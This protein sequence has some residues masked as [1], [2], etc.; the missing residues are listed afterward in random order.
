M[1][2][3][4]GPWIFDEDGRRYLDLV[5]SWG[6][7]ILGHCSAPVKA[8]LAAQLERGWSFGAPTEGEVRLAELIRQ[9]MPSLEMLRLT[10]SGTEIKLD[11]LVR[12]SHVVRASL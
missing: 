8:A 1:R 3:G 9:R 12:V 11:V 5:L 10:S 6:P 4:E 7:L 2:R